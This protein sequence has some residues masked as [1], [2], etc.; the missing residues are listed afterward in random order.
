M[1]A[2]APPPPRRPPLPA[3]A[4]ALLAFLAAALVVSDELGSMGGDSAE[5]VLLSKALR[6]GV[7]YRTT[8]APGEPAPHALYPPVWSI[9]LLPFSGAAPGSFL[10]AHLLLAALSGAAVFV[11]ARLFERRGLPPWPAAAGALAP[12]L[13][14]LWLRCA[15]DLL[16][17]IPFLLFASL[18]LLLL[19]PGRRERIPDRNLALAAAAAAIA[20]LTRTSGLALVI[21]VVAVL[22]LDRRARGR[23]AWIAA[24]AL[25][26]VCGGWF[27][28]G[29]V[30]GG[31]ATSYGAQLAE[32]SGGLIE[33]TWEGLRRTYLPGSPAYLFPR[34]GWHWDAAGWA[35]WMLAIAGMGWAPSKRRPFFLPE[36]FLLLTLLMQ[37]A[38]PFRDPRFALPLAALLVPFA[39][40]GVLRLLRSLEDRLRSPDRPDLARREIATALLAAFALV[41]NL[42]FWFARVRPAAH[43]VPPA[44]APG[45]HDP[46]GF[47]DTWF[48]S[49]EQFREAAP[50]LGS[51]LHAC[52]LVRAGGDAFPPGPVLASNPRVA[53]LLCGRPAVKA[54]DAA[55]PADLAELARREGVALVL[56]DRFRGGGSEALRAWR[57]AGTGDLE[58][59]VALPGGVRVLRAKR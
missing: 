43:R 30:A 37:S 55:S 12:A 13:S 29:R 14:I 35:L 7:G 26:V 8:W 31:A 36:A 22:C 44:V 33:R 19:E 11:L 51:F 58:E 59:A 10:G 27:L 47:T 54:P 24:G 18:A 17:E 25:V 32:G 40:T 42:E 9:L 45:G 6:E 56:V 53:A 34:R 21:P 57:D 3:L 16:S 52:D 49:D 5:Y 15:G 38:W 23:T 20:F 28:Y 39:L 2:P 48:W 41:P 50:S 46:A 1:E 4:A